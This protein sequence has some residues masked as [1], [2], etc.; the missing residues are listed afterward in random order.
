M[1]MVVNERGL[2]EM[3]AASDEQKKLGICASLP[4]SALRRLMQL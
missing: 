3:C 4:P 2:C 1:K